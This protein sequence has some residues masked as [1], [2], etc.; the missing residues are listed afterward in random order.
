MKIAITGAPGVGKTT[1][2]RKL[3][4]LV[5]LKAGGI[6][7][8]DIR[9]GRVRVGFAITDISTGRRGVLSHISLREGPRVGKYVV[10]LKD[11]KRIAIPAI[12]RALKEADLVVIDEI[13]PMELKSLEFIK[14]VEQTLESEKHLLFSIHRRANHPLL[15]RIRREFEVYEV[16]IQNRNE[17]VGRII[18]HFRRVTGLAERG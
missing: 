4:E 14:A 3:I 18:E 2:C 13:A 6:L 8:Q 12:E 17:L 16:T 1:L 7:T 5:E 9:E 15:S 11:I 10:N